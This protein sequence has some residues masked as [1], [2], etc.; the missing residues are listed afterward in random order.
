MGYQITSSNQ[1]IESDGGIDFQAKKDSLVIIGQCKK[2]NWNSSDSN[3]S[4]PSVMQH[5]GVVTMKQKLYPDNEVV[6]Y[7]MTLRKFSAPARTEFA[8]EP[9]IK[10]IDFFEL[11]KLTR[12]AL[13]ILTQNNS[14][15][16]VEIVDSGPNTVAVWYDAEL[17][18]IHQ[19]I[20]ILENLIASADVELE[21]EQHKIQQTQKL[22]MNELI[23]IYREIDLL[24]TH[25][26]FL[27][28]LRAKRVKE[29]EADEKLTQNFTHSQDKINQDYDEL[30]EEFTNLADNVLNEKD[31]A[32]VKNIYKE[33][34]HLYHPDKHQEHADQ[35]TKIFQAINEAKTKLEIL[36]DIKSNPHRYFGGKI[37]SAVNITK[38]QLSDYLVSL[39]S[40]L[41]VIQTQLETIK[42]SENSRLYTMYYADRPTFEAIIESKKT[43]LQAQLKFLQH[44]LVELED[45]ENS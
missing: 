36:R 2:S 17:D 14:S 1:T 18:Q 27:R 37:P 44:E 13:E 7:F 43:I 24:Q 20:E 8:N 45:E 35:Y 30:E 26:R 12:E 15:Q 11:Q 5:Y 42:E 40:K 3:I 31:L 25:I 28:E 29:E 10:L 41:L 16:K 19:E 34:A 32:E 38:T 4:H 39:Q 21:Q 33:L 22:I 23:D 9:K 6:G